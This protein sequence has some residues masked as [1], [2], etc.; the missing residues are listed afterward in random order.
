M[1]LNKRWIINPYNGN[2]YYVPCGTCKA[3]IAEKAGKRA[4]R[5]VNNFSKD[6]TCLFCHFT[7]AN[8]CL[9]YVT[10]SDILKFKDLNERDEKFNT[11]IKTLRNEEKRFYLLP[12]YRDS[13]N[14]RVRFSSSWHTSKHRIVK[15]H[16]QIDVLPFEVS[17]IKFFDFWQKGYFHPTNHFLDDSLSICYFKDIVDYFKRLRAYVIYHKEIFTDPTECKFTY[18]VCSEYGE[19]YSRAHFHALI[20]VKR[21]CVE[22]WRTA[23]AAN[24]LFDDYNITYKRIEIAKKPA[25]YVSTY[26]N[27]TL[28]LPV[29]LQQS[30]V[31]PKWTF[32]QNF[33][34]G[35][36]VFKFPQ[37]IESISKGKAQYVTRIIDKSG[38]YTD[39]S[40]P[41]P[42]Y[43]TN[44]YFPR[45]KGM[46]NLTIHETFNVFENPIRL[47]DYA[48]KCNIKSKLEL[49]KIVN[50]L[51]NKRKQFYELSKF[52]PITETY[53]SPL[54]SSTFNDTFAYWCL[55]C[56]SAK[57]RSQW[58][59][60]F[61]KQTSPL[62]I[63][64]SYDNYA[65]TF[66]KVEHKEFEKFDMLNFE[67]DPNYYPENISKTEMY[68][69]KYESQ[70]KSHKVKNKIYGKYKQKS[71][72]SSALF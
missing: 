25:S 64:Y 66:D 34:F 22:K 67:C 50:Y 36:D 23:I 40:I 71:E 51:S 18:F 10:W 61:D 24:W 58:F 11:V 6:Y 13:F 5:I 65:D 14:R 68:L 54:L 1:C 59:N 17:V 16:S 29:L 56:H 37:V 39:R 45:F 38:V 7:Y 21:G 52:Y 70:N 48:T 30:S 26:V 33:G 53:D 35:N 27:G 31:M 46:Y 72:S 8:D 63:I 9:P 15:P 44:K 32:S 55:A 2:R 4:N 49:N 19:N 41:L 43:V 42:S 3:C 28:E 47:G 20:W 12:L 57:K 60:I 62:K 69:H